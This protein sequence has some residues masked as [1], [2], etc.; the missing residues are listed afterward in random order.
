[1]LGKGGDRW[2]PRSA[3]AAT[4]IAADARTAVIMPIANEDVA[5]VFARMRATHESV[6][7]T[8]HGDRFD[9]FVLSDTADPDTRVAEVAAWFDLCRAIG[10]GHVFY[11]WR[12]HRIKRKSG[13]VA[14]FCRRWGRRYRYM[15]VLDADS[16]MTGLHRDSCIRRGNPDAGILQTA[17]RATATRCDASSSSRPASTARCPPPASTTGSSANRTTGLQRDHPHRAVHPHCA[18]PS[19]HRQPVGR[20]PVARFRRGGADA[21]SGWCGGFPTSRQNQEMPPN[22][23]DELRAIAAVPGQPDELRPALLKGLHYIASGS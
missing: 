5:G 7:R 4:P 12:A 3:D 10:F 17:P 2:H 8:G 16:A 14:D 20:D 13:N 15:V 19:P 9:F 6:M 22:L 23:I 18:R 21:A 1:M 11:R